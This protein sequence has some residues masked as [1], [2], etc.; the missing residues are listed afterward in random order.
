M[1]HLLTIILALL[2]LAADAADALTFDGAQATSIGIYIKGLRTD[3][4]LCE[5]YADLGLTPASV[6][7]AL[8]TAS[9]LST[10]G[11]DTTFTT[12]VY[13]DGS[14]RGDT[15]H[16][17]LVIDAVN[18]PTLESCNF[19]SRLGFCDS[20]AAHLKAMGI[21]AIDGAVAVKEKLT[22]AGPNMKWE[23]EDIPWPYG[24]GLHGLNWRDNFVKVTPAT[25]RISPEAPG[26]ELSVVKSRTNDIVRGVCSN[27]LIVY[28]RDPAD[29]KYS[30]N[31]SVPDPA[32]VFKA[33]LTATL[34]RSGI[35]VGKKKLPTTDDH[36][37]VYSQQSPAW[38]EI[39]KSLMVRSDN[40]FAEGMLRTLAPDDSRKAAISYECELWTSRG[41]D[42]RYATIFD[43]SGLTRANRLSAR[44]LGSILE[45]MARSDYAATYA[46]FFPRAGR[47]GT[48]RNF[49]P[50]SPLTGQIALKTGSVSGV[51]TYAG[52]KLDDNG[53]P[54]HVIVVLVNGF[55]CPRKE[56][57]EAT[58]TLLNSIFLP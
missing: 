43:G 25:R 57:R 38:G 26:L 46:G 41:I 33:E 40:L 2:A 22:D 14:R 45:W 17:N 4:V 47:D 21:T 50:K 48:L 52:Y 53:R 49:L 12:S 51:Q 13:L 11:A 34:K 18:D 54:T 19:K 15:W 5:S 55:F 56:V 7:K 24:T 29:K 16:G 8:T 1:K 44:F 36:A 32:A 30:I 10:H 20:I 39:M 31:V 27:R 9:V 58:E 37:P 42:T 6:M 28:T 35:S 3:S 23:C